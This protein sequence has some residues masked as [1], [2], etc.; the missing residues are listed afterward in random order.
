MGK[1]KR[2]D[3]AN[4]YNAESIQILD[5]HDAVRRRPAMYIGNTSSLGLHHLVFEVL[6]NSIDEV[7]AGYC[8][9]IDVY[10]HYDNSV[11]IV[12]DG[13]GIP[14]E[15]HPVEKDKSTVEVVMTKLHAGGKFT[16]KAYQFSGG[17]HGVGVS[18][19]NFL[20]EWL[21]VE[22]RRNNAV[23]FQR[24]ETGKPVT[25]LEKI[26]K[27]RH[28]GTRVRFRPD[29]AIF[30]TIEF[31]YDT[32]ANRFRELAFLNAGVTII[33]NDERTSKEARFFFKGGIRE[34]VKN[35]NEAKTTLNS[36]PIFLE[37]TR[38]YVK[39]EATDT[40]DEV[41]VEVAIQYND[42]Y[43]EILY[44]FANNINNRDG[45]SHAMGFRRA[46]TRTLNDYAKR[47]DMLKK[48]PE[49]LT[50]DD[51]REGLTAVVSVKLSEP[52]FEGQT[53]SK[54]LNPEIAGLVEQIVNE[55]LNEFLE[56]NPPIA[57]K[58]MDKVINAA[59]ARHA[60]RRA[61]E[62]V[63][64][65]AMEIGTLPSK[66]ADCAEKDKTLTELYIVEGDSAGGSAKLGRD[67]HFQAV[68]PLRGKIINVEKARLNKVLSNEEIRILITAIGTGIGEEN[69]N[70]EKLRYAKVILMTDA[71]VDGA[72]IRTLLL[73]FF[74]RQM[75]PLLENGHI[76]IA[77]PPLYKIKKGKVERYLDKEEDKDRFLLEQGF[78]EATVFVIGKRKAERK[79]TAKEV[80][81]LMESLLQ[82]QQ[83][84][85][86]IE[87]KGIDFSFY[88]RN[89]DN[90]GRFPRFMVVHGKHTKFAYEEKDLAQYFENGANGNGQ[91]NG[92]SDM[93]S[94]SDKEENKGKHIN[95]HNII[96]IP[97]SKT[98]EE[99]WN[100]LTCLGINPELFRYVEKEDQNDNKA[101]RI[102]D[103]KGESAAY[104]LQEL[105]KIISDIG[106]K[107]ISIQRY[108]GLGEMNPDQLWETTMNPKTRTIMQVTLEDA[109]EAER[110][111]SILMGDQVEPRRNFIQEH[112][113]KVK[114]LDI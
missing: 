50:G 45:G 13:R 106:S 64:K 78:D 66:L 107:G 3:D 60:A 30:E 61:R 7:L 67:R 86:T 114:N 16:H 105:I 40:K 68:L 90:K 74:Y 24:Y 10:I 97:E 44:T 103:T 59:Q 37:S 83:V 73:T 96:E 46:L 100:N 38:E 2:L 75:R 62:I 35:L 47:N 1:K 70:L 91:E 20:S 42:S 76:Y 92:I 94:S 22:I 87:R 99:L 93:F 80:R 65:S 81:N 28:N 31:S 63:R 29:P 58:I 9:K 85:H 82:L 41:K 6:D 101:F 71:D 69:F 54:L 49:G 26:G 53:K 102:V 55:G 15:N 56:E 89:R 33:L 111:C 39:D 51:V 23:Y 32:L 8:N 84:Y 112:A 25:P 108:K 43:S 88:L 57:R 52:Q 109:I 4:L 110:I 5:G 79:L 77:Q 98:V 34:F 18:V 19:V 36:K 14:I 27:S 95:S 17:L 48:I 113:P 72:H 12:D 104:S 11:T 21:E